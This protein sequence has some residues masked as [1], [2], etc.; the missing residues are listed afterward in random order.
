LPAWLRIWLD[1]QKQYWSVKK[2]YRDVIVFFKVG[3]FYELYEGALTLL[4]HCLMMLACCGLLTIVHGTYADDAQVGH[5]VLD[6]KM[7]I[8]GVGHCRQVCL[9][10]FCAQSNY[11]KSSNSIILSMLR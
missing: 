7:T 8:T 3:K 2:Q 9:S 10:L 6:W 11:H 5:D 1:S 4:V